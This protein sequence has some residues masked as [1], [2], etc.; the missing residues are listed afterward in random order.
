MD[1]TQKSDFTYYPLENTRD[2]D[3]LIEAIGDARIVLLGEASHGTSQYYTWRTAI[4]KRLF[5]EKGF[6]FMAVE[7][8]WPECYQVNNYI[9]GEQSEYTSAAELL[10]VFN[11][12][13]TWM[14]SNWEVAALV[15]W[16]R[17]YNQAPSRKK[18]GFYGLDVY[19][20][21]ES[22]Q[23]V[24]KYLE[25]KDGSAVKAAK[26]AFQC[27]EPF[28]D[29]PQEYARAI[30]MVSHDCEEEVVALLKTL[31]IKAIASTATP[32]DQFD[33]EQN[34]LV[35]VNAEK[36]YRAML[37]GGSSS[38]NVRDTH[39]METLTRLLDFYG[40]DSKAIVWEHNTHVGD[41]RATDMVRQR[42]VNVG[43]LAR[44]TYGRENVFIAGFGSYRGSVMAAD[45]WGEPMQI[46][47]VPEARTGS[48]EHQ[49]HRVGAANKLILSRDMVR[50]KSLQQPISHRAIGV[51]YHPDMEQY[52]NYVP[53]VIHERYDAFLYIDQ[54]EA[55][56][57]MHT[58]ISKH[59]PPDL[60]PWNE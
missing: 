26:K 17:Q 29:D 22:L 60:Y 39:M 1:R 27:F 33:A 14:W 48:W 45:E 53:S 30:A 38:W 44:E 50:A 2:L 52:G 21:N 11:R 4:S 36:Y 16:M 28:T 49:L 57:P 31:R 9:K 7:G 40:S 18:V 58:P 35:A 19:S 20:L 3:P 54:T 47:T 8:D 55:L 25:R 41:A 24:V 34:A 23:E 56:H 32:D 10:L 13:P 43:Q 6:D 51:V 46:M 5:R 12:W 42:M 15:D 37:Q 59:Q